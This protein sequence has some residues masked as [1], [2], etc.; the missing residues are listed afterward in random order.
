MSLRTLT[1]DLLVSTPFAEAF[2]T[3][4]PQS[5]AYASATKFTSHTP[6]VMGL[7]QWIGR[8]MQGR[9]LGVEDLLPGDE[10]IP[11]CP[12]SSITPCRRS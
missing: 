5:R 9:R 3:A 8:P 6:H 10:G 11:V 4:A 12:F 1:S 2:H 7:R